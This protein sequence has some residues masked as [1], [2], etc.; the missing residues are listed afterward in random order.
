MVWLNCGLNLTK[1]KS[2]IVYMSI[3]Q[4][5]LEKEMN[6]YERFRCDIAYYNCYV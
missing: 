3:K 4:G 2:E 1:Q 5:I 6:F